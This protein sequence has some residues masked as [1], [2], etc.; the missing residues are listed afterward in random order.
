LRSRLAVGH[1]LEIDS[2]PD[3]LAYLLRKIAPDAWKWSLNRLGRLQSLSLVGETG[4]GVHAVSLDSELFE[5]NSARAAQVYQSAFLGA[6]SL[7]ILRVAGEPCRPGLLEAFAPEIIFVD[8][9]SGLPPGFKV[10]S[11]L[12]LQENWIAG[13]ANPKA[14]TAFE[15][16]YSDAVYAAERQAEVSRAHFDLRAL[17]LWEGFHKIERDGVS[18]LN[19]VWT[20][21]ARKASFFLP[22]IKAGPVNI[23][24]NLVGVA[25]RSLEG[26]RL[27]VDGRAAELKA[28]ADDHIVAE[29]DN[30]RT[31][32][33]MQISIVH[34]SLQETPDG[35]RELG[36]AVNSVSVESL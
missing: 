33:A 12:P 20:G 14:G 24:L 5:A 34:A 2:P 25:G 29:A 10:F 9:A 17:I 1:L 13:H 27:Y 18:G 16:L 21:A 15:A 4:A 36:M 11:D 6:S 35:S 7:R 22:R 23:K 19:W 31:E 28:L 30:Q 3:A 8:K 32:P 26:L